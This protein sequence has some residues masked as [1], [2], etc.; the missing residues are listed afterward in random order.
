MSGGFLGAGFEQRSNALMSASD[1]NKFETALRA[2]GEA[3]LKLQFADGRTLSVSTGWRAGDQEGWLGTDDA[4]IMGDLAERLSQLLH[5]QGVAAT[6]VAWEQDGAF[7]LSV[8]SDDLVGASQLSIGGHN[9]S[10]EAIDP[11]G[12][13]GGLRDGVFARRFEAG[14]VAAA[15]ELFI[16]KADLHHQRRR[17]QTITIDGGEDGIDAEN[18]DRKAQC[19]IAREEYFRRSVFVRRKRRAICAWMRSMR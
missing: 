16:G 13:A 5:E 3:V 18:A 7:G 6:V 1:A 17:L 12:M 14:A 8:L 15:D 2:A 9:A 4:A 10:F 11:P 19:P